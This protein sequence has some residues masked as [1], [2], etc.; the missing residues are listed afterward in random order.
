MLESHI[1]RMEEFFLAKR[2]V[3]KRHRAGFEGPL[4]RAVIC[5]R[6]NEDNRDPPVG[7]N[8]L[9]LQ[10]ESVHARH[11]HIE[12]QACRIARLIRTQ[13]RFRRRETLRPKAD[14]SD[15]IVEGIPKRVVIVD[16]RNERNPGHVTRISS[17]SFLENTLLS[18][19][20]NFY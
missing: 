12:N 1:Y 2:F 8:D 5:V 16:N 4:A 19:G 9:T 6:G 14:R 10:I 17:R 3:Q 15:Q 7:R 13:K 20:R 11:S 18:A